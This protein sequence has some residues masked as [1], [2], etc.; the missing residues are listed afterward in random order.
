ME[1][2]PKLQYSCSVYPG[3]ALEFEATANARIIEFLP[4]IFPNAIKGSQ[5]M[6]SNEP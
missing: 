6:E 2:F 1:M 3:D 4:Q 5:Q